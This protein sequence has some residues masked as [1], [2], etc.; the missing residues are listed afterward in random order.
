MKNARGKQLLLQDPCSTIQHICFHVA[1]VKCVI[2]GPVSSAVLLRPRDFHLKGSAKPWVPFSEKSFSPVFRIVRS[3]V[4][5]RVR[6]NL[7]HEGS[8]TSPIFLGI[9]NN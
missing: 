3:N 6:V 9:L 8:F 7:V 5:N 1:L 4:H 2:Y